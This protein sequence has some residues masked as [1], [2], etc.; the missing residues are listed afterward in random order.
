LSAHSCR[1]RIGG[2]NALY[3]RLIH[4]NR[5]KNRAEEKEL[6]EDLSLSAIHR[7]IRKAGAERVGE[8][9]AEELGRVLEELGV[10]I[11][12][13]AVELSTHAGRKTVKASDVQM[14]AKPFT[15]K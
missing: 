11:A 2:E 6:S 14:A 15:E 13:Q 1:V 8:D 9:A 10:K 4:L 7:I 5:L 12:K 3:R